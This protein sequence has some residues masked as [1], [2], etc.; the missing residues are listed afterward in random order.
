[1]PLLYQVRWLC[2]SFFKMRLYNSMTF[3][4]FLI[5]HVSAYDCKWTAR[6]NTHFSK[7]VWGAINANDEVSTFRYMGARLLCIRTRRV[8]LVG[9]TA[10]GFVFGFSGNCTAAVHQFD[11]KT[12]MRT[13]YSPLWFSA[14]EKKTRGGEEKGWV[15]WTRFHGFLSLGGRLGEK[16]CQTNR[17]D[18]TYYMSKDK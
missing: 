10:R 7:L 17:T 15:A 16:M 1:M 4:F 9:N 2:S 3:V 8:I 12:R 5:I 18:V 6:K 13:R 11:Q 14:I